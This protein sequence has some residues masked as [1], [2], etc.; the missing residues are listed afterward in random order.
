MAVFGEVFLVETGAGLE[1]EYGVYVVE[2]EAAQ[3]GYVVGV[4]CDMLRYFF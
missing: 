1:F 3:G 2:S 4:G